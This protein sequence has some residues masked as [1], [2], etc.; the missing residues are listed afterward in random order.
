MTQLNLGAGPH[1]APAPW[2]N[3]DRVYVEGRIEPDLILPSGSPADLVDHFEAGTVTHVYLGHVLEHVA[4]DGVPRFLSELAGLLSVD[5]EVCVVGPDVNRAIAGA[6]V[7]IYPWSLVDACLEGPDPQIDGDDFSHDG[8]R[9]Q[10]N[11]TEERVV[12]ALQAAGFRYVT[13]WRPG[14]LPR[15]WPIV[16]R[17]DWQ[18]AV[19]AV[20]P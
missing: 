4:W 2:V 12:G 16:S 1:R 8:A 18:M 14:R 7:G 19:T 3:V 9:H 20:K 6:A 13:R 17:V 11:C 15:V 10:W 5:G